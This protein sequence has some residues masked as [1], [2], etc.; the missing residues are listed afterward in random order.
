MGGLLPVLII[1]V[2]HSMK[3]NRTEKTTTYV[4]ICVIMCM[5]S[6]IKYNHN[7]Y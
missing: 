6:K 5:Y 4:L 1:N 2:S 3:R 7:F